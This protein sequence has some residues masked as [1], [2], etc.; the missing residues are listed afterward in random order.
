MTTHTIAKYNHKDV[1]FD[2][3]TLQLTIDNV[4]K[5]MD[6]LSECSESMLS[7]EQTALLCEYI[8]L[9]QYVQ[10]MKQL[11]K[12]G[13]LNIKTPLNNQFISPELTR[14]YTIW[15]TRLQKTIE[16]LFD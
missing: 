14:Q 15:E 1:Q 5:P 6:I 10:G 12:T 7:T 2:T 8:A 16:Q 13:Q 11:T 4:P 3:N 9:S